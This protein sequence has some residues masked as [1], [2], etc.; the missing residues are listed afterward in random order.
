MG[1]YKKSR[2]LTII[3]RLECQKDHE[4]E[5]FFHFSE[6]CQI[7]QVGSNSFEAANGKKR[8]Y[9]RLDTQLKPEL[10]CGSENPVSGWVSRTFGVKEPTF[11]I[12]AR[13]RVTGPAQFL[14][15]I[16]AVISHPSDCLGFGL[17]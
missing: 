12:I 7:R 5:I 3:D 13:A 15:E 2:T 9:I 11:T 6:K 17:S 14:S 4:I 1:L 10:Y 16:A 8:L